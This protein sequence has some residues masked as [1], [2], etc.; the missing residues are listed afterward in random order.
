MAVQ[1]RGTFPGLYDNV[2]KDIFTLL[3]GALKE[4]EPIWSQ[5]INE[6]KSDRKFERVMSVTGVG[7]IPEKGEGSPYTSQ[8]IKEGWT[9]DFLHTEFGAMFEVTQ[10]ALEDDQFDQLS[11]HAMWFMFAARVVVEKRGALLYNNGFT[12]ELSPD[13]VPIFSSSHQ[14]KGGGTARNILAAAADLSA[15]SL[16]QALIDF[17]TETKVEAGQLV[18]PVQAL[19]LHVAPAN[20]FNA[21]RLINSQLRPGVADNDVN[22]L[23]RRNWTVVVNPYLTDADAWFL[24]ASSKQQHGMRSYTRVPLSMEPPM[25]DPRTRNRM[26]PIRWRRSFGN[27]FWQNTFASPGV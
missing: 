16:E 3:K 27:A 12:T 7:D 19:T 13:G 23:K 5:V 8:V 6:K 17:Q 11:Q 26:Y 25:T 10:T 22:A 2:D 18:A 24:Q 21:H 9:K 4:L 20:E 15:S 14:L 1:V